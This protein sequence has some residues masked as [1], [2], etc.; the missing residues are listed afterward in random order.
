MIGMLPTEIERAATLLTP[1]LFLHEMGH[2]MGF[3]HFA[4]ANRPPGWDER[5]RLDGNSISPLGDTNPDEDFAE[6][7]WQY[8]RSDAGH[9]DP[10]PRIVFPNRFAGF[11]A[12]ETAPLRFTMTDDN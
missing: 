9:L 5:I 12:L 7:G 11:D 4:F 3:W 6:A 2:V 1:H 8:L 10:R